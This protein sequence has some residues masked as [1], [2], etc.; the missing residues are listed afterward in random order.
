M[1]YTQ[2]SGVKR[3]SSC[4]AAA[5]LTKQMG[6]IHIKVMSRETAIYFVSELPLNFCYFKV[7]SSVVMVTIM[8]K[9]SLGA[10]SANSDNLLMTFGSDGNDCCMPLEWWCSATVGNALAARIREVQASRVQFQ[11]WCTDHC[12]ISFSKIFASTCSDQLSLSSQGVDKSSTS[13]GW[14]L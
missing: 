3:Y 10:K 6:A 8:G 2:Y 4:K 11:P 5:I 14:G 1:N 13:F 7:F 12:G 9:A